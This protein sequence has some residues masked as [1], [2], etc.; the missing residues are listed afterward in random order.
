MHFRIFS[1]RVLTDICIW[2]FYDRILTHL[3][4]FSDTF[5]Q[6]TVFWQISDRYLTVFCNFRG[7]MVP[8]TK[9][10]PGVI[11][12]AMWQPWVMRSISSHAYPKTSLRTLSVNHFQRVLAKS[13]YIFGSKIWGQATCKSNF[14]L[15]APKVLILQLSEGLGCLQPERFYGS[16]DHREIL[17]AETPGRRDRFDKFWA[18][19]Y[20]L[21]LRY[22]QK[23]VF[24]LFSVLNWKFQL[25]LFY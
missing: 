16:T 14:I 1:Y 25:F 5:L 23:G 7:T 12:C 24:R 13:C 2:Q 22:C 8:T 18:K 4:L 11:G 17:C 6:L 9:V 3:W 19:V 20:F 10:I 21:K 15:I